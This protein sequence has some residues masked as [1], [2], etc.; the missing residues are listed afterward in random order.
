MLAG[1]VPADHLADLDPDRPGAGEFPGRHAGEDGGQQLPGGGQQVLPLAGP[2]G[3]QDRIAAGDQPL[4]GK[5]GRGDLGEVLLIEQGQ[6]EGPVVGHELFD[7]VG[8]QRGDP[9]V[10]GWPLRPVLPLVQGL[11]PGAGDH[12]PVA[13]HD[14]FLQAELLPHH[15]RD[16][17]EG[18]GVAGV[19]GEHADRD[20]TAFGVGEQPV[21]DLQRAL[22]AVPGIPAGGQRAVRA[23]HPRAGQVEQRHP[24]RVRGRGE[25]PAGELALDGVLP[26]FQPV[27]RRVGLV[28]G[29]ILQAE[30]GAERDIAPPGQRGQLR[31]RVRDPRDDQGQRQV[32]RPARR[33]EQRGQAQFARHGVHGGDVAVRQGPGD[34]DRLGG[35]DQLLA[36]QP[37]VDQFD[38]VVRQ[39]GQVG[40][41]LVLDLAAVA[42]GAP[43]IGRGVVLTAALLVDVAGL[44]DS[45][46]V[47]FPGAPRH[48]RIILVFRRATHDDTRRILT[49]LQT[50][51][52]SNPQFRVQC[53][54]RVTATSV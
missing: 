45:D 20:R 19:A 2:V 8:A 1:L 52:P 11:D 22:L 48:S 41:G 21:L 6:L 5:V 46:Y 47:D 36:L 54:R 13:D 7:G 50:L 35:G 39:C 9:P 4:A 3:G 44:A 10:G 53:L 32:P 34:G 29:G 23:F 31:A 42:V 33:A 12:A 27:H 25:M 17:G 30:V 16:G 40:H 28:G 38:D 26:G 18:A 51:I 37:G 49:T 15:V 14:H 43:Q 24:G